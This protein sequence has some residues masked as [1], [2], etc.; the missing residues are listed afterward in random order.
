LK[1][2]EFLDAVRSLLGYKVNFLDNGRV[3]LISVYSS[4]EERPSF[5]FTSGLHDEGTMQFV[6]SASQRYMEESKEMYEH[7][8]SD[9]GSIPAFLSRVTLDLV[10]QQARQHQ[11]QE[12]EQQQTGEQHSQS[13]QVSR[14]RPHYAVPEE[15]FTQNSDMLMDM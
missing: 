2:D 11:Q 13:D 1:A 9:L 12:M 14:Q 15:D 7:Y 3:E 4:P 6:G 10:D 8:V 5:V